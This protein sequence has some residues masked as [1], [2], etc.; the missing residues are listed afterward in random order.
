MQY[1]KNTVPMAIG[2]VFSFFLNA[3]CYVPQ[4]TRHVPTYGITW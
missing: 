3:I 1:I 2:T 4:A